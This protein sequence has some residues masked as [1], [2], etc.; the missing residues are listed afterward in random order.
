MK[1]IIINVKTSEKRVAVLEEN[2]VLEINIQQ[3]KHKEIVGNVYKGR[4]IDVL[5]GMQAA[6]VDIGLG[7]NGY[8]GREQLVS[9]HLAPPNEKEKSISQLVRQGE[10]IIVQVTKEGAD[11]KGPKLT[12]LIEFP[13]SSL[14]YLP[15]GN[16]VAVSRK[17]KEEEERDRWRRFG[18]A[19]LQ[20]EEGL[21]VRT[22]CENQDEVK[23]L[24]ELEFGRSRYQS[25]QK[26]QEQLK[27]PSL[28]F[29]ANN[30]VDKILLEHRLETIKEIV[31]DD[32]QMYRQLKE[33][34]G[35]EKVSY[36]RGKEN[37]FSF[38]GIEKEIER[39]LK[40]IVWLENGAYL[41]IEQTEALTIIDVNTGKFQGKENLR[42]TVF[43]VNL[44]AAKEIA[45][46]LMLRDISGIILIDFIDMKIIDERQKV[47]QA[48][49]SVSQKDRNRVTIHGFTSLGILEITRKKTRNDLSAII[50]TNC[51]TCSGTGRIDS[52]ETVVFK[53]EREL[54]EQQG[55]DHDAV[56]IEATEEVKHVFL[57]EHNV[58]KKR[59][60]EALSIK[61]YITEL[62]SSRH[63]YTI[64]QIGSNDEIRARL[65]PLS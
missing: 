64:R 42:D 3:P 23:I 20:N 61:I 29:D 50:Q 39:G 62:V 17:M 32:A 15:F 24:K 9:Y 28:L 33:Q 37:I 19:Y 25:L 11:R 57:G 14:V 10:E 53:L 51:P 1:T 52:P 43:K 35:E 34:L 18:K 44:A 21:I 41:L 56:W 59:L 45:Y 5:P 49:R 16:Y 60:E 4:V 26:Q 40:S 63:D 38:Y 54:W 8:I 48:L 31:I 6:F 46:Q 22:A 13:S 55:M 36:Y 2:K 12:G 58:H 30:L 65:H 7:R 27:A 47:I